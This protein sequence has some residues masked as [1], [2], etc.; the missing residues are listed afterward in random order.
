M[1][2]YI[3]V[4]FDGLKDAMIPTPKAF[5]LFLLFLLFYIV[6]ITLT[7]QF[8]FNYFTLFDLIVYWTFSGG[9]AVLWGF[10]IRK[11]GKL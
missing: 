3:E 7:V 2:K 6:S 5:F 11:K 10:S 8:L 4:T 1:K 9:L